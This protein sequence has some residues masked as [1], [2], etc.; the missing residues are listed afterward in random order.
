MKEV[1]Q[2]VDPNDNLSI[3]VDDAEEVAAGMLALYR[4]VKTKYSDVRRQVSA[5]TFA[6]DEV[7]VSLQAADMVSSLIRREAQVHFI[8]EPYD[9]KPLYESL[10]DPR[11]NDKLCA[12]NCLFVGKQDFMVLAEDFS[13]LKRKYPDGK[14]RLRDLR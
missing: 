1:L 5:V 14:P 4:I 12:A 9:Y 8:G 6:D 7:F 13:K 10:C 2:Y 11:G 3:V